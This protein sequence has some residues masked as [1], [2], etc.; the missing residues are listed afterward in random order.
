VAIRENYGDVEGY[1]DFIGFG[2]EKR[3]Q[4]KK[5]LLAE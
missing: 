2:P 5:A 3:E 1:L 4:L